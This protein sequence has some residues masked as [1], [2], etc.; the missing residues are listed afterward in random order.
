MPLLLVPASR[1]SPAKEP[2]KGVGN[3]DRVCDTLEVVLEAA[4]TLP[5]FGSH[6][7]ALMKSLDHVLCWDDRGSK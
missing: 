7:A 3:R 2:I 4:M 6:L 5:V 1:S